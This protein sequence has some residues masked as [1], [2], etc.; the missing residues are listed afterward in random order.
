M[1]AKLNACRGITYPALSRMGS[2]LTYSNT[3]L[4][5]LVSLVTTIN[6]NFMPIQWNVTK[7]NQNKI[8]INVILQIRFQKLH[9]VY[10]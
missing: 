6:A 8:H 3:H 4:L 1:S 10:N 2:L 7:L 5:L 9:F